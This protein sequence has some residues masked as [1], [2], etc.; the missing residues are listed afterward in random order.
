MSGSK[1]GILAAALGVV[2]ALGQ[3]TAASQANTAS[4]AI[5]ENQTGAL[6]PVDVTPNPNGRG[7]GMYIPLT[8]DQPF[9]VRFNVE[10]TKP[11]PDGS[12][13]KQK[14]Y[15]MAARDSAGY[16]YRELRD[17]VPSDSDREPA[18]VST[19]VYDAKNSTATACYPARHNCQRRSFDPGLQ[20]AGQP[21]LG[22][23]D[24]G[25]TTTVRESLGKKQMDGV[26][27]EGVRETQTVKAGVNG[28][29][30]P[31]VTT[32]ETWYSAQLQ[33]Y[34]SVMVTDPYG[35]T[36][37]VEATDLKLGEPGEEWFAIPEGYRVLVQRTVGTQVRAIPT[38][39]QTVSQHV[40]G[41]SEEQLTE[42]LK[43]V[44]AA[45]LD[46]AK[47]HAAGAPN[48]PL[49]KPLNNLNDTASNDIGN[50]R[51][52]ST[53]R[54]RLAAEVQTMQMS[55][56]RMN[57]A[58]M[59]DATARMNAA[60]RAV[61]ASPCMGKAAPGDPPTMPSSAARLEAEQKAWLQVYDAWT[62]FLK[63]LFP[64]SSAG[65]FGFMLANERANELQRMQNVERN[66]GCIPV[67]SMEASIER[68]LPGQT[69]EQLSAALK[70]V[71]A[72]VNAY[73]AAHVADQPNDNEGD[74]A[75]MLESRLSVD[76]QQQERG[77]AP[78]RDAFEEAELHLSQAFR[79][80]SESPC[81]DRHIPGDPPNAPV[82][83][84]T[85]RAEET[86][87]LAMRDAWVKFVASLYPNSGPAGFGYSM[88]EQRANE[89]REIQN[90]E[91][92]RGCRSDDGN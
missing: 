87:W 86:A 73:I 41:I 52:V 27:A 56:Q 60:Y 79:A 45:V 7:D 64:N 36:R 91:R 80:V 55:E 30:K 24:N 28:N 69:P 33:L 84:D 18:V 58:Q 9:K 26:E 90:V 62:A 61:L 54:M 11:L 2:L 92:N 6:A 49:N 83:G 1:L 63:V 16:E 70:P 22:T 76:L 13:V 66:R 23:T 89:L 57:R 53:L 51:L 46:Y 32:R 8:K 43:P 48:D 78:T 77:R 3:A 39:E 5:P 15:V 74:F 47:A 40:S 72:A 88:T 31:L 4:Q 35:A 12:L 82:S 75:R 67:E 44:D 38:L 34:L 10:I 29:S 65:G 68:I 81:I 50:S 59:D 17:P 19:M 85:L 14:Y 21:G 42:E 25:Q 37:R 20:P 71:D